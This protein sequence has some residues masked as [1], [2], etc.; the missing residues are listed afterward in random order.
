MF[1]IRPLEKQ[2]SPIPVLILLAHIIPV[3]TKIPAPPLEQT[4]YSYNMPSYQGRDK[5]Q[6]NFCSNS[7]KKRLKSLAI[8]FPAN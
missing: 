7:D 8:P 4:N 1:E 6:M 3:L 5:I 2:I